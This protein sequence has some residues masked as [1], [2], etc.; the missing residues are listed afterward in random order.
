MNSKSIVSSFKTQLLI[1]LFSPIF[2][3]VLSQQ[4]FAQVPP[5]PFAPALLLG[6]ELSHFDFF[7]AGEAK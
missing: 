6:N 5:K 2:S 1:G 4:A 7:Y 3:I